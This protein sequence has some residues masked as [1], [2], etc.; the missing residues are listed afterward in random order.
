MTKSELNAIATTALL[1]K[2]FKAAILNGKRREKLS[3]FSLPDDVV[4]DVMAI[5]ANNLHQFIYQLNE[6]VKKPSIN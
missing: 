4:V 2:E 6:I 3:Q 1:D 5:D